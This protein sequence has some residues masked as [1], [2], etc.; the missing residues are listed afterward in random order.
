MDVQNRMGGDLSKRRSGFPVF[1]QHD[2]ILKPKDC[3]GPVVDL[4]GKAIGINIA[5]AGRTDTLALPS[6]AIQPLLAELKSGK[7]SLK[8][9]TATK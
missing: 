8:E 1:L 6:E 4:D 5:R 7:L 3:G 2:T 9:L